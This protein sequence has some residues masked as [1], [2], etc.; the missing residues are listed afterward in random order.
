MGSDMLAKVRWVE[1]IRMQGKTGSG[2][3]LIIDGAPQ[4]GGQNS[5]PRP[6]ELVLLGTVACTAADVI[7][8]L[9]KAKQSI[10]DCVVSATASRAE[11]PPQVF[12]A[13]ALRYTVTG[14]MLDRKQVERA[15]L[16]SQNETS[17]K[18][19]RAG[20]AARSP[21]ASRETYQVDRRAASEDTKSFAFGVG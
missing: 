19:L 14:R 17:A 1:G 3:S 4:H 11:N 8:I 9:R 13:I 18:P 12:T 16:L 6:M 20:S 10:V 7:T 5:G 15:V 21:A 2:H